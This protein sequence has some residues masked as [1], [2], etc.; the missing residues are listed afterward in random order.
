LSEKGLT[1]IVDKFLQTNFLLA[2]E[3]E[4]GF[5]FGRVVRRRICQWRP[6]KLIDANSNAVNIGPSTNQTELRFRDPR[7]TANDIL[8]LSSNTSIGGYAWVL[9]GAI[10]IKPQYINAYPREPEGKDIS[11]HFP[12]VDPTRPPSGDDTGYINELNSPYLR[13]TDWLEIVIPP[14][15]HLGCEYYNKDA[16]RTFQPVLNLLFCLYMFQP[17]SGPK[18]APLIKAIALRQVP[19]A[20]LTVGWGD[21]PLPLGSSLED[22]WNVTPQSLDQAAGGP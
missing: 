1:P 16:A 4:E 20:F 19:A 8:Y 2:L 18:Y 5:V 21:I 7:N 22:D 9:H 11:G 10:G 13:P 15:Q 6:Y 14:G 3:F 17:L 12:N